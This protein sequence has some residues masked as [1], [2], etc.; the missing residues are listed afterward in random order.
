[1]GE[2]PRRS[3]QLQ[4]DLTMKRALPNER[5]IDKNRKMIV[6]F[7]D[8]RAQKNREILIKNLRKTKVFG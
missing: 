8:M 6:S 2:K 7:A 3:N 1:M 5:K 4:F